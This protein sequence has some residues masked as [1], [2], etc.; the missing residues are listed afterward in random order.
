MS[1]RARWPIAALAVVACAVPG[2]ALGQDGERKQDN[3]ALAVTETDGGRA[4]DFSWEVIRQKRGPVDSFNASRAVAVC[5]DCRAAAIAFQVV[6]AWGDGSEQNS[7]RNRAE[8]I[9][10]FC[11]SCHVYAGAKQVT[12]TM[13]GPTRFTGEGRATLADVRNKIRALEFSD[14]NAGALEAAV[15]AQWARVIEAVVEQTERIDGE[16]SLM[17]EDLDEREADDA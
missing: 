6:L 16:G 9:N 14:L 17:I 4:F 8:A 11:T 15:D 12:A 5:T 1:R 10:A 13:N 2:V 3:F 7:A